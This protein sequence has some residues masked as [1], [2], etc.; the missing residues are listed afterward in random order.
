MG[1]A[2]L[3]LG[4]AKEAVVY[5]RQAIEQIP[6]DKDALF[7]LA[8]A[9]YALGHVSQ[10]QNI[11]KHLRPDPAVGANASLFSGIIH[12]N[13]RHNEQAIEDFEI[14]LRHESISPEVLIDTQYRLAIMYLK[15]NNVEKALH[16]FKVI[17]NAQPDYKDIQTLLVKYEELNANKNLQIYLSANTSEFVALCRKIVL[18]YFPQ[19]KV[20]I[21]N[22]SV[23]T[24][25]WDVS[26]DIIASVLSEQS[27]IV[28]RFIRSEGIVG[29]VLIRGFHAHVKDIKATKGFC[30]TAGSFTDEAKRYIEARFIDLIEREQLLR[31]LSGLDIN[32]GMGK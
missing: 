11:F 22:I 17:A 8:E 4:K 3:G 14:G 26:V 7:C 10:A 1:R 30:F 31:M 16:L 29:E 13:L 19:G 27:E 28:F 12:M 6:N 15:K 24:G 20:K 9:Y 2:Y 23:N 5:I 18:G 25:E 21:M 32:S